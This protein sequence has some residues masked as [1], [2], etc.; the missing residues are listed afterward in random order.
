MN[1]ISLLYSFYTDKR[2][3]R[4]DTEMKDVTKLTGKDFTAWLRKQVRLAGRNVVVGYVGDHINNPLE[5]WLK[6]LTG[7]YVCGTS[8]DGYEIGRQEYFLSQE[9][10]D[11]SICVFDGETDNLPDC[12]YREITAWEMLQEASQ[13]INSNTLLFA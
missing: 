7:G 5:M 1:T 13:Y 10:Q 6:D 8:C 2:Y 4:E 3:L 11:F 9:F 12:M